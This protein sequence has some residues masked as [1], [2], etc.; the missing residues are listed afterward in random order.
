[1][2]EE[3]EW[4]TINR[5]GEVIK[6]PFTARELW[7]TIVDKKTEMLRQHLTPQYLIIWEGYKPF[8]EIA[9]KRCWDY[10]NDT[11]GQLSTFLG[12]QICW[13]QRPEVIEVY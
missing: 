11:N 10:S 9:M 1:M 6:K 4:Y 3:P 2:N 5:N 7:D 8:F 12:L 13:T